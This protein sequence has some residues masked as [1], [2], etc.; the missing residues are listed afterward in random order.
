MRY[1][2]LNRAALMFD[3][4]FL[5]PEYVKDFLLLKADF[6]KEDQRRNDD[7]AD[8]VFTQP[9]TAAIVSA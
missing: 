2:A 1:H 9:S 7:S 8:S 6:E 4:S 5:W 3:L